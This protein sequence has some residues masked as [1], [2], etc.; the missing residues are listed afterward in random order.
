MLDFGASERWPA[1]QC[2]RKW[3]ELHAGHSPGATPSAAA[4]GGRGGSVPRYAGPAAA[5]GA[6]AHAGLPYDQLSL[7]DACSVSDGQPYGQPLQ[8]TSAYAGSHFQQPAADFG[9]SQFN[10][11]SFLSESWTSRHPSPVD[12]LLRAPSPTPAMAVLAAVRAA[13]HSPAPVSRHYPGPAIARPSSALDFMPRSSPRMS[14]RVAT[15]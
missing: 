4:A 1:T 14:P 13:S 9:A 12:P 11:P 10:Q 8:Y 3:E 2:A 6:F 15:F 5:F 7:S